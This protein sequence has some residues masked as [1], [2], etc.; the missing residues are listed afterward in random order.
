MALNAFYRIARNTMSMYFKV[1]EPTASE[2]SYNSI[3]VRI[4]VQMKNVQVE[5][6]FWRYVTQKQNHICVHSASIDCGTWG[7]GF[8][9][10]KNSPFAKHPWNLKVLSNNGGSVLRSLGPVMGKFNFTLFPL[11]GIIPSFSYSN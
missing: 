3:T 5:Q 11:C 9:V 1:A 4:L 8:A 7:Y 6:E 2:V 10:S